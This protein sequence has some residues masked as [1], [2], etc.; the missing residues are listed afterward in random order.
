MLTVPQAARVAGK[1]PETV[2]RW[3]RSGKLR[4]HKVGTQHVIEEA[5]LAAAME[6]AGSD[7][8]DSWRTTW[9]GEPMP[10]WVALVREARA[11]R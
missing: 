2:R 7:L 10:D 1:D 5:D 9:T 8:P 4:S 6:R 11:G 3:I